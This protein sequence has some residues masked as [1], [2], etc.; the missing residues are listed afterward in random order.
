MLVALLSRKTPRLCAARSVGWKLSESKRNLKKQKLS[1]I[2]RELAI[3]EQEDEVDRLSDRASDPGS[4]N[5]KWQRAADGSGVNSNKSKG[6]NEPGQYHVHVP[7]QLDV[8]AAS[9]E[10][11]IAQ[12]Q[13]RRKAEREAMEARAS[14]RLIPRQPLCKRP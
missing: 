14:E 12:Q 4:A 13:A 10:A 5:R 1:V 6:S 7:K 8:Q 9:R 3:A 2:Q 11:T